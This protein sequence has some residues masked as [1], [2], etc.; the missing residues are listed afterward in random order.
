MELEEEYAIHL[1]NPEN[2][3]QFL[4]KIAIKK[5]FWCSR[6]AESEQVK[7]ITKE[8]LFNELSKH[9]IDMDIVSN[10]KRIGNEAFHKFNLVVR[11]LHRTDN[12]SL[13]DIAFYLEEDLFEMKTVVGCFNE[14]NTYLLREELTKRFNYKKKK[15]KLKNFIEDSE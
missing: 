4:D 2:V 10:G 6:D 12:L 9:N 8:Q 15:T 11:K 1:Q 14:E 3:L 5:D 13:S 7:K